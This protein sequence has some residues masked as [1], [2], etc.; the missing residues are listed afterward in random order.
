MAK[1]AAIILS[2]GRAER[3]QNNHEKWQDKALVTLLGKPLLIHAVE[4]VSE[5]V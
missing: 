5:V 2:G 4:S 3:F 1:R